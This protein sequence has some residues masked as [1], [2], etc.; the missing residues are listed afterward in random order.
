MQPVSPVLGP[1]TLTAYRITCLVNGK[2]YVGITKRRLSKR[3]SCHI[4]KA[5]RGGTAPLSSAIRKYGQGNF[6]IESVAECRTISDLLATERALVLQYNSFYGG[7]NG[8]PGGDQNYGALHTEE[9]RRKRGVSIRES[10]RNRTD[11]KKSEHAR[12]LSNSKKGKPRG[13]DVSPDSTKNRSAGVRLY[14]ATHPH[15][16]LSLDSCL[17]GHKYTKEN[18]TW[19]TAPSGIKHRHCRQCKRD[20]MKRLYI[21]KPRPS[22]ALGLRPQGHPKVIV[23]CPYCRA[24]MGTV[25]CKK[26]KPS[27]S[28]NPRNRKEVFV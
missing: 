6:V 8:T 2:V 12:R 17:H 18:I 3:W 25:E 28:E 15:H 27:C 13:P 26:H 5:L 7:Y 23:Q 4:S 22:R 11:E 21:K 19:I 9:S 1:D 20:A 16:R 10:L 24:G 14:N